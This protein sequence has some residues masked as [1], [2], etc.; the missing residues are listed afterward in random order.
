MIK[1]HDK[2]GLDLYLTSSD[3]RRHDMNTSKLLKHLDA[4]RP[5]G[6]SDMSDR[7]GSILQDYR[8]KLDA[9]ARPRKFWEKPLEVRRLVIYVFTDAIWQPICHVDQPIR[10]MVDYLDQHGLR[11]AQV[12]IQFI[13]FGADQQGIERLQYLDQGLKSEIPQ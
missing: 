11:N 6:Q 9:K 8:A 3:E 2:D 5:A 13:R 10:T 4:H 1:K 12:G 7:L